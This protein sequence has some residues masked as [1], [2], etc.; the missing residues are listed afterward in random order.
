MDPFQDA[1]VATKIVVSTAPPH[2]DFLARIY[3]DKH[4][5]YQANEKNYLQCF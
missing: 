1:D 5:V 2:S 4:L 3:L